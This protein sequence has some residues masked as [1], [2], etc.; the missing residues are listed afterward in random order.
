[1]A[2]KLPSVS[3]F[4]SEQELV[5]YVGRHPE[6][7]DILF[8]ELAGTAFSY[9]NMLEDER[10][11]RVQA[12]ESA[13][14]CPLTGLP[15]WQVIE[16][17]LNYALGAAQ[18]IGKPLSVVYFDIDHFKEI[19]DEF[20]HGS[21]DCAIKLTADVLRAVYRRHAD[22]YGRTYNQGDEFIA[23]MM[24]DTASAERSV[25]LVKKALLDKK[26]P[27]PKNVRA[28]KPLEISYGIATYNNMAQR[29]ES[30]PKSLE[31][32]SKAEEQMRVDKARKRALFR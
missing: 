1:M 25:E 16:P 11:R 20:G 23:G 18:R 2:E 12:E 27:D 19:N 3:D 15:N 29:G 8:R 5:E 10:Q 14:K 32:V 4:G 7:R 22:F 31:L 24:E 6:H 13:F 17:Q 9:R 30:T 21:G 28:P 26:I